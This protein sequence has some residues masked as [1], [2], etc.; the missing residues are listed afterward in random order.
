MYSILLK[1]AVHAHG[2]GKRLGTC[3]V[4]QQCASCVMSLQ[5]VPM[6]EYASYAQAWKRHAPQYVPS[7][8]HVC[9]G[10]SCVCD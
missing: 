10:H 8:C 1:L 5:H 4:L 2:R 9:C 6:F 3:L 7:V